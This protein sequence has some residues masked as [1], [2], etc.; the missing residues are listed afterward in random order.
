MAGERYRQ[1]V[2]WPPARIILHYYFVL[3]ALAK[4]RTS[5]GERP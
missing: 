1:T 3:L 4:A 2:A 5:R